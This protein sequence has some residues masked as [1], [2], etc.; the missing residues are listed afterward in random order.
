[1]AQK[2]SFEDFKSIFARTRIQLLSSGF[3]F[4]FTATKTC[5][6]DTDAQNSKQ[7]STYTCTYKQPQFLMSTFI[8]MSIK[9]QAKKNE[10]RTK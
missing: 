10:T 7:R 3:F 6:M 4:Q 5:H 9:I 8:T 1:M 2:R